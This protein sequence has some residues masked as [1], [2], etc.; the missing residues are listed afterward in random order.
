MPRNL[1][2]LADTDILYQ[3]LHR[4]RIRSRL[5]RRCIC[6]CTGQYSPSQ[7]VAACVGVATNTGSFSKIVDPHAFTLVG[8]FIRPICALQTPEFFTTPALN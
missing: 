1:W 8:N 6:T 2:I 7:A 5:R 3:P 4:S